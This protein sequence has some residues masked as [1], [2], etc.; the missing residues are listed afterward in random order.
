MLMDC[1]KTLN[2]D[3]NS[4]Q[5]KLISEIKEAINS[6]SFGEYNYNKISICLNNKFNINDLRTAVCILIKEKKYIFNSGI[7]GNFF[8]CDKNPLI[9]FNQ[10]LISGKYHFEKFNSFVYQKV[11]TGVLTNPKL[12]ISNSIFDNELEIYKSLI[13]KINKNAQFINKEITTENVFILKLVNYINDFNINSKLETE[14]IVNYIK[15]NNLNDLFLSITSNHIYKKVLKLFSYK[16]K[17][18]KYLKLKR[19]IHEKPNREI[20]RF[21][22]SSDKYNFN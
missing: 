21:C 1:S 4:K 12:V 15:D 16:H 2:F 7:D 20:S 8:I 3:N 6:L 22:R 9:L 10:L 17:K 11:S 14:I 13:K 5:D 18:T 19:M